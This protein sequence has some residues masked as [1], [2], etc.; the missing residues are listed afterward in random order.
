VLLGLIVIGTTSVIARGWRRWRDRNLV[1]PGDPV[2]VVF[3]K[4]LY[5]APQGFPP[6]TVIDNGDTPERL[7][8]SLMASAHGSG[9][10]LLGWFQVH[11]DDARLGARL[12]AL[13][14]AKDVAGLWKLARK[15]K[16]QLVPRNMIR[17]GPV[18]G[19]LHA[20]D[21]ASKSFSED[22]IRQFS[23]GPVAELGI[24]DPPLVPV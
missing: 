19:Q 2:E 9:K 4:A 6:A 11:A 21:M 8:G 10:V 14:D 15:R 16:L 1:K 17:T 13:A 24:E 23:T 22:E 12:Q 18:D 20:A 7:V 5:E 3:G